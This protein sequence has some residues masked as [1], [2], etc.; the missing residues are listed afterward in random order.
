M[1]PPSIRRF[2]QLW[3]ASTALWAVGTRLA[4]N[5]T[6]KTLEI[7]PRT[8]PVAPYAQPVNVALVLLATILLWW[9]VARRASLLGK[10]LV[11]AVAA[12]SALRV[13]LTLFTLATSANPHPLSQGSFLL[14]AALAV[15]SAA[16]LFRPD[17]RAWFGE[18][19]AEEVD[20]EG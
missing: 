9:L 16:M 8:I 1:T 13:L 18:H 14:A 4:W 19:D 6:Q 20:D 12:W 15:A 10:W 5:R 17:A 7:D 11:M 3:F 2:A